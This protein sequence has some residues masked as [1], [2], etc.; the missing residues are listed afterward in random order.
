MATKAAA[1][2]IVHVRGNQSYYMRKSPRVLLQTVSDDAYKVKKINQD[3][4]V[5]FDMSLCLI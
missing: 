4:F 5:D 3:F 1:A 2:V